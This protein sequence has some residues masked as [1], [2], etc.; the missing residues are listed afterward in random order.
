MSTLNIAFFG[1]CMV[2]LSGKPLN[3]TF[4]GDTLNTALYLARLLSHHPI[5]IHYATGLGEEALSD[6]LLTAWHSEGIHTDLVSRV[7]NKNPGLYL[8]ETDEHGERSFHYWRTDSAATHYFDAISPLEHAIENQDIDAL[9][10]SGI[11][12]AILSDEAKARLLL[13]VKRLKI[14]NKTVFFDNNFRPQ[15]WSA[16]RAR[17]WYR[18]ILRHTDVALITEDDDMLVWGD[19]K[20]VERCKSFGCEQLVIKR[21]SE[22]CVV[23]SDLQ[24]DAKHVEVSATHVTNVVDTCAAG[25]SFA[26]GFLAGYLTQQSPTECAELGHALAGVVIQ[27]PGAI[28]PIAHTEPFHLTGA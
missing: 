28:V 26:A 13:C 8:V 27:F 18:D 3:K 20:I 6:D 11:S 15:L 24:T 2:E 14:Q 23:I 12:L 22:P 17:Q 19:T 9:Y 5:N 16:T 10:L 7:P 25:D 1:E 21:G 4:G